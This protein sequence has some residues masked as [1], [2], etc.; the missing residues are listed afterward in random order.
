MKSIIKKVEYL[1]KFY[2][3]EESKEKG[4]ELAK[5]AQEA[6]DSG[7]LSEKDI[8]RIKD[9][10]TSYT[11]AGDAYTRNCCIR[12]INAYIEKAIADNNTK[13]GG[14]TGR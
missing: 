2:S 8:A 11:L 6:I 5:A 13:A 7:R 9:E 10:L 4:R 14:R 12:Y 1:P 3:R